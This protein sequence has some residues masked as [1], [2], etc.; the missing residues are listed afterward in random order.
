MR[1][2]GLVL[3]VAVAVGSLFGESA[4]VAA[5]V[6]VS[7]KDKAILAAGVVQAGDVPAGWT[8][9]RPSGSGTVDIPGVAT[10]RSIKA[11]TVAARRAP[12]AT[13]PQFKD[14]MAVNLA[15]D[16]VYA[17]KSVRAARSYLAGYTSSDAPNCLQM[18][19]A[20]PFGPPGVQ[21]QGTPTV[22]G[23][24]DLQGV[25]DQNAGYEIVVNLTSQDQTF[26]LYW[27]LVYARVG[28]AVVHFVF[29]NAGARLPQS[30]DIMNAVIDRV[31]RFA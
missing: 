28:R 4:A 16:Q 23:L 3:V 12:N 11:A 6:K 29:N 9:S 20:R 7:K 19:F 22:S 18:V 8:S 24:T 25:G 1:R 17:F 21:V 13:S 15:D 31:K 10:C 27:D 14:P 26:A 2:A 5:A 30:T